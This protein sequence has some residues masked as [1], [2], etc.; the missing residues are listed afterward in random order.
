MLFFS[1]PL[2][3]AKVFPLNLVFILIVNTVKGSKS[4]LWPCPE[5]CNIAKILS[6]VTFLQMLFAQPT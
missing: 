6:L 3:E 4:R 5:F 2:V 1:G